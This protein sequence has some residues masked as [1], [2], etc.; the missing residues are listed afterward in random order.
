MGALPQSE[1]DASSESYDPQTEH[2]RGG[3][4]LRTM[5]R[6]S[7]GKIFSGPSLLVDE[8][9]RASGSKTIGELVVTGLGGDTSAFCAHMPE[10]PSQSVPSSRIRLR[11]EHHQ[12]DSGRS[13]LR[14]YRSPR[15]G[16]DL[17]NP[18]I[19]TDHPQ[20]HPRVQFVARRYRYFVHPHLLTANGRGQTFLGVYQ[21]CTEDAHLEDDDEILEE[22]VRLTGLKTRTAEKYL[23][24]YRFGLEE[25]QLKMFLGAAGKGVSASSTNFLHMMGTLAALGIR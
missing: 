7:D 22:I 18:G 19:P 14:I 9:L 2:T 15:I 16:L 10:M 13:K 11:L 17:S 5:R 23:A 21:H 24:E 20:D 8:I 3:I 25:A 1:S 4:L 6:L 12:Q